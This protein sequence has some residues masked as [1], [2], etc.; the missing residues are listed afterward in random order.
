MEKILKIVVVAAVA[1]CGIILVISLLTHK[2][3]EA[4]RAQE[5][6][7]RVQYLQSKANEVV[8]GIEYIKDTRT[9]LCFA[10]WWGGLYSHGKSI[11]TV[12]CEA[13]P[14]NLLTVAE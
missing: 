10:Y 5:E 11:A 1:V 14:S 7:Q 9:G 6:V 3:Q 13:I 8:S 12:P 2:N 4:V